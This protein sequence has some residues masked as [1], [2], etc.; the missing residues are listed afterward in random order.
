MHIKI[1][2]NLYLLTNPIPKGE[3]EAEIENLFDG[4]T[5]AHEIDGKK[6]SLCGD[7]D[8]SKFYGKEIFSKYISSNYKTLDF[9]RFKPLLD[10]LNQIISSYK[11]E[12]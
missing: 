4:D 6:F 7:F 2:D 9:S 11:D 8:N 1:S 5:L 10:A 3:K 12:G